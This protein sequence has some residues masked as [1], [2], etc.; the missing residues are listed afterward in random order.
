[1]ATT[2]TSPPVLDL[3]ALERANSDPHLR[4]SRE[5]V[6]TLIRVA[7]AAQK[8]INTR[9]YQ[10]YLSPGDKSQPYLAGQFEDNLDGLTVTLK[11]NYTQFDLNPA[12]RRRAERIEQRL[13][14]DRA[15]VEREPK[16]DWMRGDDPFRWP[17]VFV[18]N[19]MVLDDFCGVYLTTVEP[20]RCGLPEAHPIHHT[21][22]GK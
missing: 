10:R 2:I 9:E 21:L 1:M 20:V 19:S 11:G 8:V 18:Q 17:H 16:L 6:Y 3:D 12:E 4:V 13:R 14:A 7:R 22:K 5:A 15:E